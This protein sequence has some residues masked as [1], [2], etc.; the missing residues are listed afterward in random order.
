[1]ESFNYSIKTEIFFGKGKISNLGDIL[2]KYGKSVL[3]VYGGGSIKK[4]GLYD[5]AKDILNKNNIKFIELSGVEPNPRID[6]VRKG[7]KLVREN[8]IDVILPIGGGSTIDC[9]KAISGASFYDGDPWDIVKDPRKIPNKIIPIVSI[10]TL[11]ATGSEMDPFAVIS[12]MDMN[13]KLGFSNENLR[14]VASILDPEYTYSVPK[15]QTA[16]GTCDIMSHVFEAYFTR[17]DDAYIQ[18]R[19]AEVVLKTCIEYGIV[20]YN[21]P[22]NY[23]ARANLMWASSLA[24]NG[25]LSC[26]KDNTAWSVHPIEHELSAYYDITH[27]VGLA[28]L[29]PHWM[30]FVLNDNT[31]D[32]FVKFGINVWDIDKTLPKYEIANLAINM[33]EEYFRKLNVP[34]SLSEL[35]IDNKNFEIMAEKAVEHGGLKYAYVPLNKDDVVEIFNKSL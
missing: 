31:V 17:K 15:S 32:K 9:A 20:A 27:G 30:R 26:G 1:M 10:L 18:D 7:V 19:M 4:I 35:N 29:T 34:K 21:D 6:T 14:P 13:E 8:K 16:A 11:A 24:I 5:K 22:E 25:L 28:I 2:L 3:L 33:T 23:D 12:N